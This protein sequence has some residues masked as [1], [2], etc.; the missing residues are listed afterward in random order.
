[1]L[2]LVL[3]WNLFFGKSA[4]RVQRG[5]NPEIEINTRL[6]GTDKKKKEA[7]I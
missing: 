1:L 2:F 5:N 7:R 3:H 4:L 6:K